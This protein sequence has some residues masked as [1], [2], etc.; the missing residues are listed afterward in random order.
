[1][2]ALGVVLVVVVLVV[3]LIVVLVVAVLVVRVGVRSP[4]TVAIQMAVRHPNLLESEQ[5]TE[6]R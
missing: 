3:V 1:M 6:E 5:E 4:L 2:V